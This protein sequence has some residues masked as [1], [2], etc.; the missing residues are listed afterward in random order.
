MSGVP[1]QDE[2]HGD[3]PLI[4]HRHEMALD[5]SFT[6][7][8][9]FAK[10]IGHLYPSLVHVEWQEWR[11]WW[12]N[13]Y[14]MRRLTER[15]GADFVARAVKCAQIVGRGSA[16]D[17]RARRSV[18]RAIRQRGGYLPYADRP[19]AGRRDYHGLD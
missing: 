12:S 4:L 13:A 5:D 16:K 11:E 7:S 2:A 14:I 8:N 18:M 17:E 1:E 6:W 15:F 9:A 19:L 10:Y 3:I